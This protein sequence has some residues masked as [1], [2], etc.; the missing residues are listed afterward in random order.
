MPAR[1]PLPWLQPPRSWYQL[2]SWRRIR[3]RHLAREPL[4]RYCLAKGLVVPA[5]VV[6]HVK[7]HNGNWNEFLR[8]ERQ[9]LCEHCH[10]SD[11]RFADLNG[12]ARISFGPDGWP[13]EETKPDAAADF[14][15]NERDNDQLELETEDLQS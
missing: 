10:N 5:T 12:R 7:P 4:C 6:D 11:K 15:L 9:S 8:G 1:R 13:I 3:R 2:E 14:S